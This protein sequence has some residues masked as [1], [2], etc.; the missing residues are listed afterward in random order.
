[1]DLRKNCNFVLGNLEKQLHV[2]FNVRRKRESWKAS[3]PH[4]MFFSHF[5]PN[6]VEILRILSSWEKWKNLGKPPAFPPTAPLIIRAGLP[7]VV[8]GGWQLDA[9]AHLRVQSIL[10]IPLPLLQLKKN[11]YRWVT[12]GGNWVTMGDNGWQW[13]TL[14]WHWLKIWE[15]KASCKSPSHSYNW[16]RKCF[17]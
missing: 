14:G 2:S 13:L 16:K 9:L 10:Q 12:M 11:S 8:G 3:C 15:C 1:M 5:H 17:F 4:C 7:R 6:L